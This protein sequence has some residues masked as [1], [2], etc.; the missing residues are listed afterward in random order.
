[1]AVFTPVSEAQ[2][3]ELVSQLGLGTLTELR[4]IEGGNRPVDDELVD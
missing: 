4:G 3:A 2:A 1:M